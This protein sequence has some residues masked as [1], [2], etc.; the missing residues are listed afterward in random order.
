MK[1]HSLLVV[2]DDSALLYSIKKILT[3]ETMNVITA[4]SA[5]EGLSRFQQDSPNAVLLDLRI[6]ETSGLDVL[7]EFKRHN[8]SIPVI[9]F[10][11]FSTTNSAIEAVKNGAFDYLLKPVDLFKL[12]ATVERA[13]LHSPS[14]AED[15]GHNS[16]HAPFVPGRDI[17]LIGS[18]PVMLD[19]YKQIGRF[20]P[21]NSNILI[22]GESGTGKELVA[23][24]IH[25]YSKRR[26]SHFLAINCAALSET[27]LES[28]LFGHEKGAFTGADRRRKGKFEYA[29]GGTLFLDEIGDMAEPTQ[30]KILRVLQ[31]QK[32]QRL[33]GNESIATDVRIVAATNK[34]LLALVNQGKFRA[35]LYYRLNVFSIRVPPLR[36]RKGDLPELTHYFVECFKQE[37]AKDR[38]HIDPLVIDTLQD[39]AWPGNIREL[40]STVK[41]ALAHATGPMIMKDHLPAA[42]ILSVSNPQLVQEAQFNTLEQKSIRSLLEDLMKRQ[43]SDLYHKVTTTIDDIL[44][45]MVLEHTHGNLQHACELLGISRNTLKAKMRL[46]AAQKGS[47]NSIFN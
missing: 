6:N 18:S 35:D 26:D 32:F 1:Q 23:N 3:S 14:P 17:N 44:I 46:Q 10:T 42:I 7:K 25:Q 8:E 39:Y 36:E 12:K 30:A 28:E 33:G 37:F 47:H 38:I 24:A 45:P 27:L 43:D 19:V 11:A 13:I 40:Q 9:M 5:H 31:E 20:A 2:D 22:T 29:S 21:S 34:N 15:L 16:S 4:A 41:H